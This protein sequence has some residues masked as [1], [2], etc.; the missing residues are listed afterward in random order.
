[1]R[2]DTDHPRHVPGQCPDCGSAIPTR[3]VL[4][5]YET[6]DGRPAMYAECPDCREIVHPA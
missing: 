4:I 5:E 2:S 3:R 6:A 1:M